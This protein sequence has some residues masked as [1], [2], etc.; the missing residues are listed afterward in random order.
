MQRCIAG[1]FTVFEATKLRLRQNPD[2]KLAV[3]AK[4][5]PNV[6]CPRCILRTELPKPQIE[7][8]TIDLA[9]KSVKP[10]NGIS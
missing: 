3:F 8:P 4:M 5:Q 7:K 1:Q 2:K 6:Q 10:R 9:L